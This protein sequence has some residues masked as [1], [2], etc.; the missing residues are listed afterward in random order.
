MG[1]Q[2]GDLGPGDLSR[3]DLGGPDL[4]KGDYNRG[5]QDVGDLGR[6]VLGRG[7]LGR[8][9][10]GRGVLGRGV[11]GR[12]VLGRGDYGRGVL[13]LGD[14]SFGD[15]ITQEGAA[16]GGY[17]PPNDMAASVVDTPCDGSAPADCHRNKTSWQPPNVGEVDHYGVS[18]V[19][20]TAYGVG[21][22]IT[23][24]GQTAGAQT[25]SLIDTEELPNGQ[26]SYYAR[27]I[28]G[29]GVISAPSKL[30]TVLAV[31][32]AP[33]A[34]ADSYS[35]VQGSTLTVAALGVIANDTDI[36]SPS[37]KAKLVTGPA[38]GT[39][40]LNADGS[41]TYKPNAAFYG[42]DSF[43]YTANDVDTTRSSNQATVPIEVIPLYGFVAA[44]NLPPNKA[45]KSG[46]SINL[47][48]QFTVGGVVVDSSNAQPKVK[49][50]GPSGFLA[51]YTP[52]APGGGSFESPTD[53]NKLTWTFNWK[54]VT[55]A[56]ANLPAGVTPS[57]Y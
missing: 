34:V 1:Q 57:R 52:A 40:T 49:I 12:G 19:P 47:E 35:V 46:D 4:T 43:V 55:A 5:D 50:A 24:V 6:G 33:V 48:W 3:A 26:F 53:K 14:L 15:D 54:A 25:L 9:V 42:Q 18:R 27:A 2:R 38:N 37:L 17:S 56:G 13:G 29:D 44:K 30:A 23:A 31:N 20:G 16:A 10:L 45:I 22:V 39:L 36:D 21:S 32:A 7:V 28:F 51:Y 11:L 8:G 41:F